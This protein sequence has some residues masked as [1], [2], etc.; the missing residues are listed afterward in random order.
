ML[1]VGVVILAAGESSRM[2][3]PK[4]MLE[5]RGKPLV[6]HAAL[7]AI[8]A[9]AKVAVVVGARAAEVRSALD[10]LAVTIVENL[11]FAEGMGTSIQAGLAAIEAEIDGVILML[12]DQPLVSAG[13]LKGLVETHEA[14]GMPIVAAQYSGTVG[15]PVF[16]GRE[17]FGELHALAPGHGCKGVILAHPKQSTLVPC[18]EAEVDV[19]TPADYQRVCGA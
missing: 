13:V 18:P 2:G 17:F 14:T 3:V 11:R 1:R 8:E 4:Q 5:F 15:V 12:A 6:R 7:T 19:D 16:F 9:D 10:G